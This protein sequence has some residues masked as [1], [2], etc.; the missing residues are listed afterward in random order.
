MYYYLLKLYVKLTNHTKLLFYYYYYYGGGLHIICN[1]IYV[2][3]THNYKH[4]TNGE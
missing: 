2:Q 4:V 1:Y 3:Y